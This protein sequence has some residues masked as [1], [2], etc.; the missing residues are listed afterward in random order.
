MPRSCRPSVSHLRAIDRVSAGHTSACASIH[1]ATSSASFDCSR[2]RCFVSRTSRSVLPEM[3]DRGLDEVGGVEHP[4]AVLALVAA[5]VRCSRSAGRCRRCSGRAGSGRRP[6][7]TPAWWCAPRGSPPASSRAAKCCVSSRFSG[8]ELRPKWSQLSPNRSPMSRCTSCWTR[9]NSAT[10]EAG[11]LGGQLGGRAVL[12]G[13]ADEQHLLALEP[14][15]AG[16]DVGRQHRPD[17]VAQ[18]LHA[19]DVRQRAGDE[20]PGHGLRRLPG[21]PDAP[22]TVCPV[23]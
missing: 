16:V 7:S 4:G 8:E 3:A 15:V 9:Q 13:G 22:S 14:E 17:E 1:A 19:V 10:V 21:A 12:V 11:L 6:A 5:G 18:V 20:V 23:S 2:K